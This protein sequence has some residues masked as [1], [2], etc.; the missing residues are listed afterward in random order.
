MF[1]IFIPEKLL[2]NKINKAKIQNTLCYSING[3]MADE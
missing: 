1:T 2:I 3:A